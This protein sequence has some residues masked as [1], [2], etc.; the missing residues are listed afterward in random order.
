[1]DGTAKEDT[2]IASALQSQQQ[3]QQSYE[4]THVPLTFASRN[5]NFAI[6]ISDLLSESECNAIIAMYPFCN[7]FFYLYARE[8]YKRGLPIDSYDKVATYVGIFT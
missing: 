4:P 5:H 7:D 8:P 3:Q 1:M 6:T 2:A